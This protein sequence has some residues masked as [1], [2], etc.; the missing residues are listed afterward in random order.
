MEGKIKEAKG[1]IESASCITVLRG[2]GISAESG[3]PTFREKNGLWREYRSEDLA[4]PD[5]FARDTRLVWEWYEWRRRIIKDAKPNL[6]HYALVELENRKSDFTLIT[7][8]IDGLHQLSGIRNLIEMQGNL[9]QIRCIGYGQKS[10]SNM[11][12]PNL[13]ATSIYRTESVM[14]IPVFLSRTSFKKLFLGS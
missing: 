11:F 5:A 4:T 9:W 14:G 1:M 6:G 3:I 12:K 8:N 10:Y 7:Q 13:S 2:A